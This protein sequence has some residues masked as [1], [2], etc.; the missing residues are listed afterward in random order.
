MYDLKCTCMFWRGFL[1]LSNSRPS[2]T[3][4]TL[5][6]VLMDNICPCF[7][8]QFLNLDKQGRNAIPTATTFLRRNKK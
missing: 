4:T 7:I 5:T 3:N 2:D 8:I 1:I 6:D